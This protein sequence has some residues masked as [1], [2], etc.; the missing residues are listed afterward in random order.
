MKYINSNK[1]DIFCNCFLTAVHSEL[2]RKR[3]Y[4]CVNY[5]SNGSHTDMDHNTFLNSA[6]AIVDQLKKVEG[7]DLTDFKNLKNFGVKVE[8]AMFKST[9]GINTHKGLIFLILFVYREWL[10]NTDYSEI[11]KSIKEFSKE[12]TCDYTNPQNSAKLH[13]FGINDIRTFP[14]TGYETVFNF[15]DLIKEN[16]WDED[17]KTLYLIANIDDTTTIKRSDI[18]TLKFLQNRALEILNNYDERLADELDKFYV[19]NN[20]SSGGIADVLTTANLILNL[21]GGKNAKIMD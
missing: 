20:I 11:S 10:L 12:L 1:I 7:S 16:Y 2:S 4:G 21:Y 5:T 6:S 8:E 15:I 3:G 18:K 9:N 14:L 13:T 17:K 19:K